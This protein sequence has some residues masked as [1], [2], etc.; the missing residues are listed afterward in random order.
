MLTYRTGAAGAP[1]VAKAMAEY[2]AKEAA[3]PGLSEKMAEYYGEGLMNADGAI[4]AAIPQRDMHAS[5]AGLLGIDPSKPLTTMQVA[6]LLAG[7]RADGTDIPGKKKASSKQVRIAYVDFTLSAP[8]SL[9]VAL[10][11]A[12][13]DAERAMLD[14]A[15]RDAVRK[16]I[17]VIS[18]AIGTVSKGDT[19]V[20]FEREAGHVAVLTFEH[21]TARPTAK[22]AHKENGVADT[23]LVDVGVFGDM[24]RHT[25]CIIPAVAIT[26][27]GRVGSIHQHAIKDRIHEWGS[28]YQ[29]FLA[30]NLRRHGVDVGLDSRP[31]LHI[32]ER[33]AVLRDVPQRIVDLFSKRTADGEA[34][35]RKVAQERGLDYD[36]MPSAK[37][38]DFLTSSMA[39]RRLHKESGAE[40]EAWKAQAKAAGYTHRSVLRPGEGRG[41]APQVERL[42][43][44]YEVSLPL[45]EEQF[46]SRAVIEGYMPRVAA[47]KG[48]IETGIEKAA[49]VNSITAAHRSEGVRQDGQS[50]IV[51]WAFDPGLRFARLTTQLSA[52]QENEA[53]DIL[54]TAHADKSASLSP[55]AVQ[56][57]VDRAEADGFDFSTGH[58][59]KQR[60]VIDKIAAGGRATAAVG[61]AG[62]GKST[63]LRPI[64]SAWQEDGR[65]VY[66]VTLGWRQ[67]EGLKSAGI[68]NIRKSA[69][70]FAANKTTLTEAGIEEQKTF[71]LTPFLSR[72][73]SGKIKLDRNSALAIDEIALIGTKQ[74]LRLARLQRQ[75]G[76]QIV[77][78]GDDKQGQ[79]IEAGSTID[80]FRRAF[81]EENVPQLISTIRQVKERD[82]ETALMFRDG[83]AK[84]ALDRK[85]EDGT[86][87]VVPGGYED[88]VKATVDLWF[89]RRDANVGRADYSL[90][91]SVPTNADGRAIGDEIHRRR[92]ARGEIGADIATV[93]ATDQN[94][95][96]YSLDLA[97]GDMVRLFDRVS[98]KDESGRSGFVGN[99]GTVLEVVGVDLHHLVVRKASGKKASIEWE[100]LRAGG[101]FIRLARGDAVTIDARQ[102]ETLT[103]HIT[104]MPAGSAAVNGFKAY[105]AESRQREASW[106]ITSHGAEKSE[107]EQRR[108][109]G[110]PRNKDTNPVGQH[111]DIIANMGRNLSRQPTKTLA[112]NFLERAV[113]LKSG[114]IGAMQAAWF[115]QE[116]RQAANE[117]AVVS[118]VT[119]AQHAEPAPQTAPLSV[120]P[121]PMTADDWRRA[122]EAADQAPAP[123]PEHRGAGPAPEPEH[124]GA[125]P[126]PEPVQP[127]PYP[128]PNRQERPKMSEAEIQTEFAN[129]LEAIGLKLP[130][131]PIMDGEK[132]SVPVEGN[133]KGRKSGW[134]R[135]FADGHRVSVAGNSFNGMQVK[136]KPTGSVTT[137]M[138]AADR[139]REQRDRAASISAAMEAEAK[140]EAAGAAQAEKLWKAGRPAHPKHAYLAKKGIKPGFLRQAP[141]GTIAIMNDGKRVAI[142]GRLLVPMRDVDGKLWNVQM[143]ARDGGK[144]FLPGRKKGLMTVIGK[145]TD[146]SLPLMFATGYA[147]ADTLHNTT[148]LR[149][150]V[151]F[152]DG[153]LMPVVHAVHAKHPERDKIIAGDNDHHKPGLTFN[154]AA[155]EAGRLA[156]TW[157]AGATGKAKD[158]N[159]VEYRPAGSPDWKEATKGTPETTVEIGRLIPEARYEVRVFSSSYPAPQ[160]NGGVK[161]AKEA[162][163]AVGGRAV[164]PPFA[165]GDPGTD[166]NDLERTA[167][168]DAARAA[169]IEQGVPIARHATPTLKPLTPAQRQAH[170]PTVERQQQIGQERT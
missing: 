97:A 122:M 19:R 161:S 110:D 66:G 144:M 14:K 164:I 104:S 146:P 13:T 76:F 32:N 102:S 67:T 47:A 96:R 116:T 26:D 153:N 124:R 127:P 163:A 82:R 53:I 37:K 58:G 63:L 56:R 5:I 157:P 2:L 148:A 135:G 120:E 105:V 89:S 72:V 129:R 27:S 25:H 166:Y 117:P 79:S 59:L 133:K 121:A 28:I 94:G 119:L 52:D 169:L 74:I 145:E 75:Y 69:K 83:N 114:A 24:Q 151:A 91:I 18:A 6:S 115:R 65:D 139:E 34:E 137:G 40:V 44:A 42:K 141:A 61:I 73:E 103:E 71:A 15:H 109:I 43:R 107:I 156:V 86:L 45:L 155:D 1:G 149:T 111:F 4:T 88:A 136:W 152:D 87:L 99:N 20:N 130:G 170:A 143:I 106:I 77:G 22:I 84:E 41:L 131:P 118:P 113:R 128:T 12:P 162:A 140:K 123:E 98:G 23:V 9:S 81:G 150:V 80:L 142:G 68:G 55:E 60:E 3:A 168:P 90:G 85:D 92:R 125:G 95:E 8:K 154:L 64:V 62:S 36:N 138:S 39:A 38:I 126:A 17:K 31:G 51:H 165:P 112:T 93:E 134:Y 101:D 159:T 147:T 11:L 35:A 70:R 33:M 160:I 54:R 48:L 132:H 10:E 29:A 46:A 7:Q 16:T 50:T 21:R 57:A 49:E 158:G 78:I 108:S 167:G 100:D 30:T